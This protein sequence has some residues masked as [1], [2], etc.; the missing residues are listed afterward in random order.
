MEREAEPSAFLRAWR[1]LDY[2][3]TAKWAALLS[4]VGLGLLTIA[5][6]GCL[7]LFAELIVNRGHI[8]SFRDLA[9][10]DQDNF[11]LWWAGLPEAERNAL[12][13]NVGLVEATD[14]SCSAR[15]RVYR[16]R[17]DFDRGKPAGELA[18]RR[19]KC[20]LSD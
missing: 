3:P 20:E 12:V 15:V 10:R 7:W 8:P 16:T 1:Y 19:E 2:N 5:L 9:R 18:L 4:G 17:A 6:L 11:R 13:S 14:A